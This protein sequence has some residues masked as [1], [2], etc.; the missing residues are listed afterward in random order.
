MDKINNGRA[1]SE[2]IFERAV[3]IKASDTQTLTYL[4]EYHGDRDELW[5]LV[6]QHGVETARWN[7]RYIAAIVWEEDDL[8]A[9]IPTPVVGEI[10]GG[11]DCE[12]CTAKRFG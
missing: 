1:V 2:I 6:K 11:C 4:V 3:S 12:A 7:T 9:P 5:V 8:P 10:N